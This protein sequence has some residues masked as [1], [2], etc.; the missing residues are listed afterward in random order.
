MTDEDALHE[1]RQ[2]WGIE[3]AVQH[4]Q[5]DTQSGQKPYA[6]GICKDVLFIMHGQGDSWEEAFADADAE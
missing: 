6:V 1:A 2:R 4:R 5:A 3:G